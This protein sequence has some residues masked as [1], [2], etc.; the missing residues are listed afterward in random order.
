M[1]IAPKL[2]LILILATTLTAT[3][4]KVA[5]GARSRPPASQTRTAPH[6]SPEYMAWA[7][8]WRRADVRWRHADAPLRVEFGLHSLPAV[9]QPPRIL[10]YP[11][12]WRAAA[13]R[14]RAEAC[15][16]LA[17]SKRLRHRL[18][19]PARP[20]TAA[21]W[22]PLA[23]Y[24]G[25]PDRAH[26]TFVLVVTRESHGQPGAVNR[27]SG[28]TGLLQLYP[29]AH[30]YLAPEVNLRAGLYKYRASGW[31]PWAATAW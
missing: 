7:L 24:V 15:A 10:A 21:S 26:R 20:Y 13:L 30:R 17:E 28:A 16:R 2:V 11:S 31:A 4:P 14:W 25:W 18:T 22:W 19:C 6:A 12:A 9:A 29:G 27:S 23:R 3:I 8:S 5:D 1:R